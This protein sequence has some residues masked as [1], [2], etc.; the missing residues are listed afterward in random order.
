MKRNLLSIMGT[1]PLKRTNYTDR[2]SKDQLQSRSAF[3]VIKLILIGFAS[4]AVYLQIFF[5]GDLRSRVPEFLI[6]NFALFTIYVWA[7][8]GTNSSSAKSPLSIILGFAFAFRVILFFSQPCLSDDIHRYLWEGYLQTRGVNPFEFAPQAPELAS[9][10]NDDWLRVNNKDA[11]AIYPPLLQMVH[12]AG[13]IVF[14]SVWGFKLLFLVA[15]AALIWILLRLLRIYGRSDGNII[16]YAWNPL[17]VVEIAGS[18][19]HDA[20]VVAL[21]LAAALFTLTAQHGKALLSLAGSILCKLYPVACL[22]LFLKR[23]PW[24]HSAWLPLILVAGYL[25]YA[26]AGSR[27]FSALLY[28]REKWRFNGFLFLQLNEHLKDERQVERL[29][30]LLVTVVI[31]VCLARKLEL[32][33]QL[34]WVTGAILLCAPTLFPWYLIWMVPFLCFFPNPAWLLLTALSPLS[35]YVLIDWWTLGLWRQNDLFLKLQYVPFY[36]LLIWHFLRVW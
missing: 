29:M 10:R 36:G 19:H 15:E 14:R 22:P 30:L 21:L 26:S 2:T 12:A 3:S 17:V 32:L 27:L 31:G 34:Y 18:G 23:L 6:C 9:L 16:L 28:Y 7:A 33:E 8:V 5:L 13:F 25:P 1:G 11:A 24:R 20:C 35:Y 4:I